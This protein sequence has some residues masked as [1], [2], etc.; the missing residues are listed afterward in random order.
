MD[1]I[2]LNIIK[3]EYAGMPKDYMKSKT[4][5]ETINGNGAERQKRTHIVC[6]MARAV[7]TIYAFIL[8]WT[9]DFTLLVT[10]M[11]N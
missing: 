5:L 9:S 4:E 7:A 2:N 8:T 10:S 6:Y 11:E 3:T 1:T